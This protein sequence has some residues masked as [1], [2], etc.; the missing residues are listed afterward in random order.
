MN[1]NTF[2]EIQ[3]LPLKAYN[4]AVFYSNLYSDHGKAAAED[5]AIQFSAS[6]RLAMA[7]IISAVK[8]FGVKKVQ[9]IVTRDLEFPEYMPAPEP[10]IVVKA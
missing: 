7:Q 9:E 6:E 1:F 8:Q 10:E 2:D 5:Y 4:R 3:H